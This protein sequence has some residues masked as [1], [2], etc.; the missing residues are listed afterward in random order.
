MEE[1]RNQPR[2]Q[3]KNMSVDIFDGVGFFS[4]A[5]RDF[6][7]YGLCLKQIPSSLED[8]MKR[9][10]VVVS[11]RDKNFRMIVRPRWFNYDG[12]TQDIG[13][14]IIDSPLEWQKFIDE[15]MKEDSS[16]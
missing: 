12:Y 6:S 3:L 13:V 9:L 7:R 2:L 1:N 15:Q 8:G 5:I 11:G 14:R 4:G 16:G 10:T